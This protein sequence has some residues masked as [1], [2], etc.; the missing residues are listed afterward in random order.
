VRKVVDA[1]QR[2]LFGLTQRNARGRTSLLH[3]QGL[4]RD[5][6]FRGRRLA[7]R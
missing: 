5:R 2:F 3:I 1:V 6:V 7:L 4:V